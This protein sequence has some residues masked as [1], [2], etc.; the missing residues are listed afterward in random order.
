MRPI[1]VRNLIRAAYALTCAILAPAA[2]PAQQQVDV[3][4]R[5]GSVIDGT[6]SAARP[7]DV[8]IRGDRITFVGNAETSRVTATKTIDAKGLIVAPGFIDPHTH[9]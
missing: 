2:L 8:G 4:I 1:S 5:G 6:G 7:A 3:L 9:T